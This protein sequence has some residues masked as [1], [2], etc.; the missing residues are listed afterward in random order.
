MARVERPDEV[1]KSDSLVRKFLSGVRG[2]IPLAPEQLDIML[3]VIDARGEPL[4][5]F[6]DLGCGSGILAGA[7]LGRYPTALGA[8]VD[9]SEPMFNEAREQLSR[10]AHRLSFILADFGA[11][12]WVRSVR[13][14]APFDVIVSGYAIHHQPDDRKRQLYREIFGLLRP[15][16]LFLNMEHVASPTPWVGAMA[17]TLFVDSVHAYHTRL[18]TAKSREEVAE[19]FVLRPDKQANILALVEVQC[20]WL[21]DCGFD[22][23]DCYFKVLELALFGGRRPLA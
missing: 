8:L 15:G 10:A 18:G 11:A 23:V 14:L 19:E 9:F 16:G 7:I 3:R 12:G 1:W 4:R 5:N 17:D 21:R 20:D 6:A 22:D 13:E 2:G